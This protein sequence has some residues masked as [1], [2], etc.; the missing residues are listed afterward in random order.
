[1]KILFYPE[2]YFY[3]LE[4]Y[5]V[6][7]IFH[8]IYSW[9]VSF[10]GSV[11]MIFAIV[12]AIIVLIER[13]LYGVHKKD[14]ASF[15]TGKNEP[16]G[17]PFR[18]IALITG[19]SNGLGRK[20]A[21]NIDQKEKNID[22][23][24]LVARRRD[25]LDALASALTHKTHVLPLDLTSPDSIG[26]IES[27]LE[28][29]N[30]EVGVLI[31]CA[32]LGKIGNYQAITI[33][34][35]DRMMELNDRSA[36]DVTVTAL[37]F[38]KQGDRII[39]ICSTA[40]FQPLQHFNV[41]AASKSFLYNYSRALRMELLPRRIAVTAACPY[42]MQDTEFIPV[43]RDTKTDPTHKNPIRHFPF[44]SSSDDVARR[45]MRASRR[46]Y[47]V[48]TPGIFCTIHRFF[49]K[50]MPREVLMFFWE[51]LRRV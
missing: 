26:I 25:R 30:A 20:L 29:Y 23:I 9:L 19:A 28:K 10:C 14:P 22:E 36:V 33:E 8:D 13:F 18:R 41:Y 47:A 50:L 37:P 12:S 39:E 40:A 6:L 7:K 11:F 3:T 16:A 32:G 38:M 42:W 31:N 35:T 4:V 21:L 44:S 48:S 2:L 49:A 51:G 5:M 43:A 17:T 15:E 45:I 34:E 27:E 46:G 1:M 24:W